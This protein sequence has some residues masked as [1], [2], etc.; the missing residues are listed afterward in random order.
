MEKPGNLKPTLFLSAIPAMRQRPFWSGWIRPVPAL[1][2]NI[3]PPSRFCMGNS[4]AAIRSPGRIWFFDSGKGKEK[5]FGCDLS[6][7]IFPIEAGKTWRPYALCRRTDLRSI[8]RRTRSGNQAVIGEY[9]EFRGITQQPCLQ[10]EK[11]GSGPSPSTPSGKWSM[12][13][14]L[15]PLSGHSLRLF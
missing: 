11:C 5:F 3:Y 7:V 8:L 2:D 15:K 10:R 12:K 14:F 4:K 6:S 9:H 13:I 1:R